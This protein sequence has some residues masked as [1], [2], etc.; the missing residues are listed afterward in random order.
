MN[1]T[2]DT[3]VLSSGKHQGLRLSDLSEDGLREVWAC[4]P[5]ATDVQALRELRRERASRRRA[6]DRAKRLQTIAA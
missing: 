4:R 3:F 1:S 6:E 5:N 2:I